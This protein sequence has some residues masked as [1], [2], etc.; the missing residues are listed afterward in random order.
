MA[1]LLCGA[2]GAWYWLN[3]SR[4]LEVTVIAP[5]VI[6]VG[7]SAPVASVLD[8]SGFVV[9]RRQATV[10][11]EVTGKL[12][13]VLVEEG[14]T[15]EAGQVLARLDDATEQARLDLSRARL[16]SEQRIVREIEVSLA[17]A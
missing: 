4:A 14:M 10:A 11:A 17:D 9:A 16:S 2:I 5:D 12:T 6:E 3:L 13:E 7:S 1:L 15:V 8:A